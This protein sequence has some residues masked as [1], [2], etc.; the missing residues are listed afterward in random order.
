MQSN[1]GK[2]RQ[3]NKPSLHIN[4]GANITAKIRV[5]FCNLVAYR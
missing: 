2:A 5:K 3:Y 4:Q 1:K